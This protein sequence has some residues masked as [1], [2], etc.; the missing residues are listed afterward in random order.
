VAVSR[1]GRALLAAA[2]IAAISVTGV[3]SAT[4]HAD[5]GA[6][7]HRSAKPPAVAP[8]V[9]VSLPAGYGR[10]YDAI[11]A[12]HLH[13]IS[14]GFVVEGT[15]RCTP[16][17]GGDDVAVRDDTGVK[18]MIKTARSDGAA[19]IV[20]FGGAS[21]NELATTCTDT[22]RLTAAYRSVIDALNVTHIDFDIE[23]AAIAQPASIRRRFAAIHSLEA[24][25]HHLVVSLTVPVTPHG[26]DRFGVAALKAARRTRAHVDVLNV[27]TMDYGGK[28]E[29]GS[30]AIAVAK[31]ALTQLRR[32]DHHATYRNLGITPMIGRND[33]P[34]EIFSTGD[35]RRVVRFARLHH[36]GRLA[37]WSLDRDRQCPPRTSATAQDD[38]S[39]VGQSRLRFTH[40][41]AH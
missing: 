20:S 35:A 6:P 5:R 32:V 31:R 15:H 27:M 30:T 41:F 14:A 9:D 26:M 18:Q 16:E 21:G 3:P 22:K 2:A 37:F 40:L 36:V 4:A 33:V 7:A 24:H 23:G 19:V 17:W 10:V 13:A 29:M 12:A 11:T 34:S 1:P 8:Y 25:D 28:H 38:C 39:G